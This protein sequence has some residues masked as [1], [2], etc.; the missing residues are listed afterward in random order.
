MYLEDEVDSTLDAA[1][2]LFQR[3]GLPPWG[4]VLAARQT[5]GR[6]R[7]GRAWLS[8]SGHLYAALRL[9]EEE[10]FQAPA[11]AIRL[12]ALM[13]L[14]LE[15]LGRPTA[16]KWPNDLLTEG[17]KAA[18]ILLESRGRAL[19]A[20]IGLNLGR[21]PAGVEREAGAP[22]VGA[23]NFKKLPR[24]LWPEILFRLYGRYLETPP[25]DRPGR[26]LAE[27]GRRLIWRGR[28]VKVGNAAA[29]PPTALPGPSPDLIG[30]VLGLAANGALKL[31]L[32]R[33]LGPVVEICSGSVFLLEPQA[34]SG[35]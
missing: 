22:P 35:G 27:A 6:G 34:G 32:N 16:L 10:A 15:D 3:G 14:A 11:G 4:S 29:V 18:G 7:M 25:A 31:A 30:L 17:R 8:P 5:R 21:P 20:G 19:V 28:L 9:P 26:L 12:A 33:G 23:F 2:R 24:E 13:A 1:W